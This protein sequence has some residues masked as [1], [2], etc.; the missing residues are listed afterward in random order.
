M[1]GKDQQSLQQQ[2][3]AIY[4]IGGSLR[5]GQ[6]MEFQYL[7]PTQPL[8][9]ELPP[10]EKR[11]RE[12][13]AERERRVRQ[14]VESRQSGHLARSIT[15]SL[16]E[17]ADVASA[18]SMSIGRAALIITIATFA[19]RF[20]GMLQEV[21]FSAAFHPGTL[22]DAFN[23]A[24]YVPN[25]VFNIVA[26]GALAS[27]FIPV[28][29]EYL[30]QKRDERTAWH[31]VNVSLNLVVIGMVIMA[32]I[33]MLF[34]GQLAHLYVDDATPEQ[35]SLIVP[36]TRIMLLQSIVMGIGIIVNSVLMARKQFLMPAI[37]SMLYPVGQLVGLV[38]ALIL[39]LLHTENDVL[40]LYCETVGV[41]L[42]AVLMVGVQLP[43]LMKA[44]L[45]YRFTLDWR[46]EGVGRIV[47]QMV[48]RFANTIML[49]LSNGVDLLLISLLVTA[50]SIRGLVTFNIYAFTVVSIPMSVIVSV[51]TAAFPTMAEYAAERR[52]DRLADLLLQALRSIFFVS[53]PSCIGLIVLSLPLVQ[54][55]FEHGH[56]N[57]ISAEL[58]AIPLVGLAIGLPAQA[59]V[60][61][62]TRTFYAMRNSKTP[63]IISIWQFVLKIAVALLLLE[64][65]IWLSQHGA[66]KLLNG[67]LSPMQLE[68]AWG[69]S[70]LTFS[71]SIAG[72][73][74]AGILLWLLHQQL[75]GLRLRVLAS[76]VTR[77]LIASCAMCLIL[78]IS[79]W[80]LD[81]WLVTSPSAD[82]TIWFIA[83]VPIKLGL[84]IF[85]GS[86][87]YLK[88]ARFL[89]LLGSE[90]LG[91]VNRLLLRLRLSWI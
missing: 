55:L 22:T 32:G 81:H 14:G 25:L 7:N 67:D 17:E 56:F 70:A 68:G 34:A 20:L 2:Q 59:A 76:F 44:G 84:V 39:L 42:G 58:T 30:I 49:N 29:N 74:E 13:R 37:G 28:F 15:A 48:P 54:T 8:R 62:L 61:I 78:W 27:A 82:H 65:V 86:F 19:S 53:I 11:L 50:T 63:V 21:L 33:A 38:P 35:L 57:Y 26:G 69:M 10:R 83:M 77:I 64:P 75:G 18:P 91:P 88:A 9:L 6:G 3:Q 1:E 85:A 89:R 45:R 47:H 31:L 5:Y 16:S 87:V 36:W 52:F 46:H 51:A 12:L 60:E 40:G 73:L 79:R 66:G 4:D 80:L 72:M 90:E 41:V 23:Q 43:G 71:T 24:I